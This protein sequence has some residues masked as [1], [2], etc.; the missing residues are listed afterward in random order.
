MEFDV[1]GQLLI[2]YSA[3]IRYW[4]KNVSIMGQ[5]VSFRLQ[6]GAEERSIVQQSH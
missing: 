3:L 6:E 2:I 1:I 5:Y 4:R